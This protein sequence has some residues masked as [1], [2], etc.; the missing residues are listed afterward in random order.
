M[1]IAISGKGG[2]GK[3]TLSAALSL[4]LAERGNRV[5][6]VDAD[7]DAN[8]AAALGVSSEELKCI[9]PISKQ[10][11]LIEERTGAKVNQYGQ[12]FAMNPEVSDIA[13]N[14]ATLH[15]GVSL[16]VLGAVKRGGGGCACP[17]NVLIRALVAD[18]I[19]FRNDVLIMDM[20]AGLEHLGRATTSGVDTMLIVVEP[21]QRSLDGAR[22]I[23]EMAREIKLNDIRFVANKVDGNEDREFIEAALPDQQILGFIPYTNSL[24]RADRP[25]RSVLHGAD[26]VV[27]GIFENILLSV[28]PTTK[29]RTGSF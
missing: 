24:R 20:E 16:L 17:E 23:V 19:L 15:K 12:I 22:R 7:P 21:G 11:E 10:V 25:G 8:L 3:S 27:R 2:V 5:L 6:A 13:D 4:L 29:M 14:Y 28:H 1:K 26:E 9:V 18:L